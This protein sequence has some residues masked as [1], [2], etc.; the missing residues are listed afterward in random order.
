MWDDIKAWFKRSETIFWARLQVAVGAL[1]SVLIVSDLSPLLTNPKI[2][3]SWL[4][5]SGF[6]TEMARRRNADL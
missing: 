3:A 6:V 4:I 2:M 5:F 1:W